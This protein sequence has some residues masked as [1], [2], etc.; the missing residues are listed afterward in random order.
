MNSKKPRNLV[1]LVR[2]RLLNLAR[3]RKEDFQ[4]VLIRFGI[5]R[6]STRSIHPQLPL[7]LS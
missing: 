5:E 4:L 7:P 3:S 2:Q 1:A 6:L